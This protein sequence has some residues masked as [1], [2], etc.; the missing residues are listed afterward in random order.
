MANG[1][2]GQLVEVFNG[3]CNLSNISIAIKLADEMIKQLKGES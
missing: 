1:F 2:M 3:N